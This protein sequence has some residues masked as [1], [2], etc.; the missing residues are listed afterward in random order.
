MKKFLMSL[1]TAIFKAKIFRTKTFWITAVLIVLVS[2]IMIQCR[3]AKNREEKLEN[4]YAEVS[5]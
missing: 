3:C 4:K 1:G 5:N 2:I